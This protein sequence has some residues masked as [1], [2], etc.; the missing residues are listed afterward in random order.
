MKNQALC[1]V[2]CG[3][4]IVYHI[5]YCTEVSCCQKSTPEL[6]NDRC[7]IAQ[8]FKDRTEDRRKE[9]KVRAFVLTFQSQVHT[10][11]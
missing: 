4:M 8:H 7:D 9:S 3:S 11:L 10:Q 5:R 2:V 1:P 6:Y